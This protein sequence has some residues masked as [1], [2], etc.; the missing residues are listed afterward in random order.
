MVRLPC[1]AL[2]L[3]SVVV[4]VVLAGLTVLMA[5]CGA[6]SQLIGPRLPLS[7]DAARPDATDVLD[8]TDAR[9]DGPHDVLPD[10]PVDALDRIDVVCPAAIRSTQ[11]TTV[12]VT[13]SA[14]SSLGLPLMYLWTV[15]RGPTDSTLRP[16]PATSLA[17]NVTFDMGGEWVLRFTATDPQGHGA[18][19]TVNLYAEPAIQLLCPND[20]SNFQGANLSLRAT[21]RSTLGRTLTYR[22]SVDT[23]PT[24]ST[25]T[26]VPADQL[27][28]G[29]VLDQ[30]GDWQL[31]LVATDSGGLTASCR[32]NLHADPDVIVQCPRDVISRPFAT[33]ELAGRASS[34]LGLPL[35]YRW[36]IVTQPITSTATLSTPASINTAF[37][38]DVAG[39]WTYRFTASNVRGNHAFCTTRALAATDEAVRIEAVWNI[40]R[41]CRSCNPEGGGI[42]IDLHLANVALAG[43]HWDGIAPP[44]AD[45][46][47]ANCRCGSPGM[48][49]PVEVI[50]WP[51]TGPVNNPQ[52]DIDHIS[53]LPG[54]ENINV[55]QAEIGTQF[56]VGVHYFG[57]SEPT[58][59][60]TRVYCAGTV[61]FESEAVVM[62]RGAGSGNNLWKVGRITIT[63]G[64]C[65]FERCGAPGLLTGCIRPQNDW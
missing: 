25:S 21:A 15:E 9:N 17:T 58:P 65:T 4:V 22:W 37:T 57:G 55:R 29:F 39:N 42:D 33:I 14:T 31:H 6:R 56:D 1:S 10:L 47:Y 61:V 51:P 54:P 12:P 16:T 30:L 32:V 46:Y 63:P 45:C 38:F 53:D 5:S 28:I 18:S 34:R 13:A 24:S 20:E 64:G 2:A 36:E 43:G 23:R 44:E 41:S 48:L 3:R 27:A 26:P 8:A 19:C 11:T 59:V 50:D 49:C 40:D 62:D 52:Q 60:V 7:A 35:T